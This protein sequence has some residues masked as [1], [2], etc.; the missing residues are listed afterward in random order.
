MKFGDRG[1][2]L[3]TVHDLATFAKKAY[4]SGLVPEAFKSAEQ[5]FVCLQMGAELGLKP[6]AALRTICVI[7]GRP[8]LWGDGMLGVVRA[9]GLLTSIEE[10]IE[11]EGDKMVAI[12][13]TTRKDDGSQI[14]RR[15][16]VDDAKTA[17]LWAGANS[18]TPKLSPWTKF[19]K[20]MIQMRARG[21]CLRDHFADILSGM[22]TA[23]EVMD[24]QESFDPS[25]ANGADKAENLAK[26][27]TSDA[28]V[29]AESE[30]QPVE[31]PEPKPAEQ[32][33]SANHPT[34]ADPA[35]S[36]PSSGQQ[37]SAAASETTQ[38]AGEGNDALERFEMLVTEIA[39]KADIELGDAEKVAD[40]WLSKG[41]MTYKRA[42]LADDGRWQIIWSKAQKTDWAEKVK[43]A[44]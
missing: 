24:Y 30:A 34:P 12:C 19:P 22:A 13:R 1:L 9:S 37:Q 16:S 27:L 2:I 20:R 21:F 3:Q 43:A 17:G 14:E 28:P 38:Q 42:D 11:G 41:K 26:R 33:E 4:E 7:N 31:D 18:R 23:E 25:R 39:E 36:S 8:S 35:E 6:M 15:F 32:G 44:A 5:V 40:E 10:L 29:V